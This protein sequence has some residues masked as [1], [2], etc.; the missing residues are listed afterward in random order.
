[1]D[2]CKISLRWQ[3]LLV[4]CVFLLINSTTIFW[5][6]DYCRVLS[7]D[8]SLNSIFSKANA[9]YS[10]WTGRYLVTILTYLTINFSFYYSPLVFDVLNSF[11]SILLVLAIAKL[12]SGRGWSG[13]EGKHVF[14]A[15]FFLLVGVS[16]FGEAS[17]WKTGAIGYLWVVVA[18]LLLLIPLFES[19]FGHGPT[20]FVGLGNIVRITLLAAFSCLGLENFSISIVGC[21]LLY[22]TWVFRK[23]GWQKG[24]AWLV[25][26]C[27]ALLLFVMVLILSPGNRE[28]MKAIQKISEDGGVFHYI[29]FGKA[30]FSLYFNSWMTYLFIVLYAIEKDSRRKKM[31]L[32]L[33]LLSAASLL[34]MVAAPGIQT[35][36]R[37]NFASEIFLLMATLGLF[38][39]WIDRLS[40]S[41]EK[42]AEKIYGTTAVAMLGSIILLFIFNLQNM[43]V[44]NRRREIISSAKRS[45]GLV[46]ALPPLEINWYLKHQKN[47]SH[48]AKRFFFFA[49]FT[50]DGGGCYSRAYGL[51]AVHLEG[52]L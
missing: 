23:K 8:W 2:F 11:A 32:L 29:E 4:F 7:P 36:G 27:A 6:D 30:F 28:R 50:G 21:Y 44:D 39:D 52:A 10:S 46:V 33:F 40:K 34:V 13:V 51:N 41:S 25:V 37:K 22:V 31:A 3:L 19:F 12:A 42:L 43:E 5:S 20:Y 48:T 1:M 24:V 47:Q 15:L 45:G 49:E 17:L 16:A 18:G 26:V 9:E 38:Y 35:G 14:F